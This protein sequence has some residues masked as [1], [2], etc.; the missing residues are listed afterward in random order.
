M[1]GRKDYDGIQRYGVGIDRGLNY[2]SKSNMVLINP[3]SM[4]LRTVFIQTLPYNWFAV[5]Q[6]ETS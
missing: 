1:E 5:F 2:T 4:P 3:Y 6:Q